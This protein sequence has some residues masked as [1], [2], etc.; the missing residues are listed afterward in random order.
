MTRIL[1]AF[2][3]SI[4][5]FGS[6][7]SANYQVPPGEMTVS[8]IVVKVGSWKVIVYPDSQITV[9]PS[10]IPGLSASSGTLV[11]ISHTDPVFEYEGEGYTITFIWD[12]RLGS[13]DMII[14]DSNKNKRIET[15]EWEP[16]EE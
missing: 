5:T 11:S 8:D 9:V 15:V 2:V 3:F 7:V 6:S 10:D 13:Y 14:Y 4:V 12:K 16:E 1:L